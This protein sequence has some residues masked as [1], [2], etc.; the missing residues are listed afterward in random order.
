MSVPGDT[1]VA[2]ISLIDASGAPIT[3]AA[4]T[5]VGKKPD[6]TALAVNPVVDLG[7]GIYEVSAATSIADPVGS[8]YIQSVSNT[9]PPAVFESEWLVKP[10]GT[11]ERWAPGDVLQDF[12][13]VIAPDGSPVTG[14]TFTIVATNPAGTRLHVPAPV[15]LGNGVYRVAV[16]TSRVDPPGLYYIRLTS[17]LQPL[18]VYEVEFVTGPP[19]NITGGTSL[20]QLRRRVMSKFGDL[21]MCTATTGTDGGQFV[22]ADNLVGEP[23]RYAGRDALMVT[24]AN[25]GQ[26]RHIRGSSRDTSS[27]LFNRP[28]PFPVLEG[29]QMDITN[30]F[31]VGITFQAADSAIREAME[32]ARLRAHVPISYTIHAWDGAPIPIPVNAIGINDVYGVDENGVQHHIRRGNTRANGWMVDKPSRT[33]RISGYEATQAMSYDIVVN[34]RELP[35]LLMNDDDVTMVDAEWIVT[36][37]CAQLCL[38]VLLSRQASGDWGSKGMLYKQDAERMVTRL[39]PNIGANY[40]AVT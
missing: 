36:Y 21:L 15:D 10:I 3:G 18:Q 2:R 11:R 5:T 14:D 12:I 29:D 28:L 40:Q 16:A 39:T 8:F 31:G 7:D 17:T 4:F 30:A 22:D 33:I 19:V 1:L 38:D 9:T 26:R 24:G 34:A 37:A 32:V 20:R 13:T 25:A 6:G 23:S 35:G 27:V